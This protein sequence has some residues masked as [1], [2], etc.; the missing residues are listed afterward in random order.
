[1]F[2]SVSGVTYQVPELAKA[3]QWYRK[4]LEKEPVFASPFVIVFSVG[5]SMLIL[6][7]SFNSSAVPQVRSIAYW[8]VADVDAVYRRLLD[9]GASVHTPLSTNVFKACM[10]SL[11]DPFG[12]VF[13]IS[14]KAPVEKGSLDN[15]ASETAL[16]VAFCRALAASEEGAGLKGSD[17]LAEI[18]LPKEQLM[19]IKNPS[20]RDWIM[21]NRM[22]KG[23]T[24]EYFWVRTAY[25]DDIFKEALQADMPQIVFLGAGYDT[26]A[27]RFA[28]LN[29]NTRIFEMDSP[30]TQSRKRQLLKEAQVPIPE[31]L[32]YL[33]IDFEKHS[34]GD[35]LFEAGYNVHLPTIF[36]WEGVTYYLTSAAVDETLEFVRSNSAPGSRICFD[37][38]LDAE[39][40]SERYGVRETLESMRSGYTTEHAQF[41][42]EEGQIAAFMT[43]RGFNI[44]DHLNPEEMQK[45]L[46][47]P[48]AGS[49]GG[50]V[51]QL[52]CLVLAEVRP[53]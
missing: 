20:A 48:P 16:A 33:P 25:I 44:L 36:I 41:S 13:G 18:F 29:R 51:V 45:R 53:A 49:A 47:A 9:A 22:Q 7:Q 40:I 17:S 37:Y 2:Q 1:M 28:E 26:R 6:E 5:S 32:T 42:I 34:L 19:L 12:N 23:G 8:D 35:V 4:I 3:G 11:V 43:Q 14:G 46:S 30:S 50:R 21:K 38:I 31:R 39:D 24:Y 15:E 10:A 52:F 27:C